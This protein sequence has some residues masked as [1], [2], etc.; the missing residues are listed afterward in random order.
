[1]FIHF[2]TYSSLKITE[3]LHLIVSKYVTPVSLIFN[4][5]TSLKLNPFYILSSVIGC[6]LHI[7]SSYCIF[8]AK[9]L[10][11]VNIKWRC[12]LSTIIGSISGFRLLQNAGTV[13][14]RVCSSSCLHGKYSTLSQGLFTCFLISI[15]R[16]NCYLISEAL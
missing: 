6:V 16:T 15:T 12:I 4:F 13:Q 1:M 7:P 14:D 11:F 2:L 5:E 3:C 9:D 10:T 8:L